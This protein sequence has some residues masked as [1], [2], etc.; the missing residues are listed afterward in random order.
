MASRCQQCSDVLSAGLSRKQFPIG[1]WEAGR[2]SMITTKLNIYFL[3]LPLH[4]YK[5]TLFSHMLREGMAPCLSTC[6]P[7]GHQAMPA[8]SWCDLVAS[9]LQK[10]ISGEAYMLAFTCTNIDVYY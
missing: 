9:L 7:G 4:I 8:L 6:A 10:Y 1:S 2:A 5:Y 3:I